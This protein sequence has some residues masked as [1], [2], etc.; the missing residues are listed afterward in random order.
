MLPVTKYSEKTYQPQTVQVA[1]AAY[2]IVLFELRRGNTLAA[3]KFFS[4]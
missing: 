3:I 1:L 2:K 4:L